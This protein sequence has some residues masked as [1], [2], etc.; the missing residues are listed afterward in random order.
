MSLAQVRELEEQK[1]VEVEEVLLLPWE[2]E[3]VVFLAFSPQLGPL[4]D[5]VKVIKSS[6]LL[7]N[8]DDQNQPSSIKIKYY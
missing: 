1:R 6:I 4:D 8:A 3:L 5:R 7:N 2:E